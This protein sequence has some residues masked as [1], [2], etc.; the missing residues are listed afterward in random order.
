[1]QKCKNQPHS[2]QLLRYQTPNI[3][4][5]TATLLHKINRHTVPKV[6][7]LFRHQIRNQ[8]CEVEATKHRIEA[9]N[10]AIQEQSQRNEIVH[11]L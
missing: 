10:N 11:H 7:M 3:A 4:L 8:H 6:S 2:P 5:N 1:M 9:S